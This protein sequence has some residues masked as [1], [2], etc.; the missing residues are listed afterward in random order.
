LLELMFGLKPA[1]SL[2]KPLSLTTNHTLPARSITSDAA[3]APAQIGPCPT[4][5]PPRARLVHDSSLASLRLGFT[6]YTD[7][8]T[9][10]GHLTTANVWPER[11]EKG[12]ITARII[13]GF[14]E[15]K[16]VTAG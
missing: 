7:L 9:P 12:Q 15:R 6:A 13:T 16:E 4:N 11:D 1:S 14:D 3:R 2:L 10:I 5:T 8:D